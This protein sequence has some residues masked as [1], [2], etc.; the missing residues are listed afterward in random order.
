MT[1][2]PSYTAFKILS[3]LQRKMGINPLCGGWLQNIQYSWHFPCCEA[4]HLNP[5][6]S[7]FLR[8]YQ[9]LVKC[10]MWFKSPALT[11]NS[12][13]GSSGLVWFFVF[14]QEMTVTTYRM[15]IIFI[16]W[17]RILPFWVTPCGMVVEI[18]L[19]CWKISSLASAVGH[20][21]CCHGLA[22]QT[23]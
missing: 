6:P 18:S 15:D 14:L 20:Q 8:T 1:L 22:F 17:K 13:P 16:P 2:F 4:C 21:A 12:F 19:W 23:S 3:H 7:S 5:G 11:V 10:F 9:I